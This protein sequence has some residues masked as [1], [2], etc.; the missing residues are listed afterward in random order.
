MNQDYYNSYGRIK[1]KPGCLKQLFVLILVV[2]AIV[3]VMMV[4]VYQ[5]AKGRIDR[6]EYMAS[7]T[8]TVEIIATATLEPGK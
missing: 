2:F 5:E 4:M 3:G 1:K 8:P 7:P 6:G